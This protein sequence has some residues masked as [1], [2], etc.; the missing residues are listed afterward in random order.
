MPVSQTNL[1]TEVISRA[2][3]ER[4]LWADIVISLVLKAAE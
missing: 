2:G 4:V 3:V 1:T